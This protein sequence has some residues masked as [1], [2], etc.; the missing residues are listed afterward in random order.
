MVDVQDEALRVPPLPTQEL[1][2]L[3][4]EH[5]HLFSFSSNAAALCRTRY[6][7]SSRASTSLMQ[8]FWCLPVVLTA[9]E[10]G[11]SLAA[12]T[13]EPGKV[14][15]R[16]PQCEATHHPLG[17]ERAGRSVRQWAFLSGRGGSPVRSSSTPCLSD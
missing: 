7:S 14:V 5:G 10:A 12:D 16:E 3:I 17:V 2:V 13:G 11:D 15:L 8:V 4:F 1:G 9:L 6:S